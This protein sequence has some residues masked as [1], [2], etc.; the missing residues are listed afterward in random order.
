[1]VHIR[2]SASKVLGLP[3]FLTDVTTSIRERCLLK[4]IFANRGFYYWVM[5]IGGQCLFE[6]MWYTLS[7]I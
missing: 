1:M 3:Y 2:V 5:S 4:K 6:E 7:E